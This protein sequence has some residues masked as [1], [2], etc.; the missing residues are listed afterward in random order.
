MDE[1]YFATVESADKTVGKFS[2][3]HPEL[4]SGSIQFPFFPLGD[5]ICVKPEGAVVALEALIQ[6][7][8]ETNPSGLLWSVCPFCKT[9]YLL[10][11]NKC[12]YC[13]TPLSDERKTC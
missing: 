1:F 11:P 9:Q 3:V 6:F 4:M 2:K 8:A 12:F 5:T 7:L 10:K 13:G